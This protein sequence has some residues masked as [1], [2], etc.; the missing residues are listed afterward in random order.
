[1]KKIRARPRIA[2]VLIVTALACVAAL[3]ARAFGSNGGRVGAVQ[4]NKTAAAPVVNMDYLVRHQRK[5]SRLHRGEERDKL[6]PQ[7]VR[8]R[9]R[10]AARARTRTTTLATRRPAFPAEASP[11]LADNFNAVDDNHV[12]IPP[13][14]DGAVG[15]THLMVAV[16][17]TVR[18]Q[19]KTG[20]VLS[21]V[22][23]DSFFAGVTTST[24]FDPHVLYDPVAGRWIVTAVTAD[25]GERAELLLAVSKTSDPTGEWY[26]YR[27]FDDDILP[28]ATDPYDWGDYPQIGFNKNWIVVS[29]NMFGNG[30]LDCSDT[31]GFCGTKTFVFDKAAAGAGTLTAPTSV[32]TTAPETNDFSLAPA[33]AYDANAADLYLVENYFGPA[34]MI[35]LWRIS[36]PAGAPSRSFVGTVALPSGLSS[37]ADFPHFDFAALG[38]APQKDSVEKIDLNDARF[39]QCI[40]RGALWC[41]HTVF[42]PT[43]L[44]TH[45]AVQW[46]EID[47]VANSAFQVGR[48]EDPTA[49]DSSGFFYGFPSIAVN[50]LNDVLVGYS[51]FAETE[52]A[53]ANYSFRGCGDTLNTM[54]DSV[55]YKAGAGKYEKAYSGSSN[56]WGDYSATWPDPSDDS[57]L[58]TLQ[59]YA[60]APR[61]TPPP[62]DTGN[63][64]TWWGKLGPQAPGPLMTPAPTSTDHT[65]GTPSSNQVVHVAWPASNGCTAAYAYRWSQTASDIPD[66]ATDSTLLGTATSVASPTL[67]FGTSW[68]LH[69]VAYDGAGNASSVAH[70]GPFPIVAPPPPPPPLP[71]CVVPSLTRQT[72]V[73]AQGALTAAHCTLGGVGR[74]F[75]RSVPRNLII[76]QSVPAGTHLANTAPVAVV[77]S[78]G[79]KKKPPPKV[80]LCYR[81]HT[82]KV[83]KKVAKKL[84]KRGAKRGACKKKHR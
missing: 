27:T 50:K 83:T 46:L 2:G 59:E 30:F 28:P 71:D 47:P 8:E 3:G 62:T 33:A 12:F 55:R 70:L 67:P 84:L 22:T 76:S 78:L 53:G 48:I 5:Q 36:G 11:P 44:P 26:R 10:L 77:V 42:L 61:T 34:K 19:T 79:A 72:I 52:Y 66:R 58:W 18:I 21:S 23:L 6:P 60:A 24:A 51:S 37:W 16:N 39:T 25:L 49:T 73:A 56:R 82:V 7:W 45:S 20:T 41:A 38:S 81:H 1:L 13:D 74:A 69:L 64:G 65:P 40:D 35:K 29:L 43:S 80:T 31:G 75:S 57:T 9:E 68:F 63:W 14:T 54:R 32:F 15:P 17:G 4:P